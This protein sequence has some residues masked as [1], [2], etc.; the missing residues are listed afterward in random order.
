MGKA[1]LFP[2]NEPV[3]VLV[4]I[5]TAFAVQQGLLLL[6]PAPE[7]YRKAKTSASKI[8]SVNICNFSLGRG[9]APNY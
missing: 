1:R 3:V 2:F 9:F 6:L 5:C 8:I 7:G 4:I